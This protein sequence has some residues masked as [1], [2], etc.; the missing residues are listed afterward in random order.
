MSVDPRDNYGECAACTAEV[1]EPQPCAVCVAHGETHLRFCVGC[2]AECVKCG[3]VCCHVHLPTDSNFCDRCAPASEGRA[4][5]GEPWVVWSHEHDAWWGPDQR[6]YAENV[7]GAG[8]Y[9]E[10]VAKQIERDANDIGQRKESAMPL[11]MAIT[12]WRRPG[13]VAERFIPART[14]AGGSA[15]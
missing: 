9:T 2:S 5:A 8:V 13:T 3:E 11:A 6:G 10:A 15:R 12:A 14:L 1:F 4:P 7:L